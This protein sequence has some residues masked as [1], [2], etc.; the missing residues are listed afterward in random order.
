[1]TRIS[2]PAPPNLFRHIASFGTKSDQ[3]VARVAA[4]LAQPRVRDGLIVLLV[5]IFAAWNLLYPFDLWYIMNGDTLFPVQAQYYGIFDF[6]PP[7]SSNVFPD[8][9]LHL[10]LAPVLPDP[11]W[12]KQAVGWLLFLGMLTLVGMRKGV[13][14]AA[15]I[16]ALYTLSGFHFIDS[17]SHYALPALLL[18]YHLSRPRWLRLSMLAL[19]VFSDVLIVLPV[20]VLLLEDRDDVPLWQSLLAIALGALIGEVFYSELS[21]SLMEIAVVAPAF[22]VAALIAKRLGLLP[23]MCVGLAIALVV[24]VLSGLL[25]ARYVLPVVAS[26]VVIY[27]TDRP[28]RWNW[29]LLALPAAMA[30]IFTTTVNAGPYFADLARY[31]CFLDALVARNITNI[32]ADH[33]T[34]PILDIESRQRGQALTIT[35][36]DFEDNATDLWMAPY[37]MAGRPTRFAI[38]NDDVCARIANHPDYCSQLA[39]APVVSVERVCDSLDLVTY[40]ATIPANHR[41]R[42]MGKLDS[43]IHHIRHYLGKFVPALRPVGQDPGHARQHLTS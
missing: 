43:L 13:P 19:V 36:V 32:A 23:L 12:Q 41:S 20:I 5:V 10:A 21:A 27:S 17:T 6:R 16:V 22:A 37:D 26:F 8:M 14:A 1:M 35:Q 31:N 34:A 39:A 40:D 33:W 29:R 9:L 25:A 38:R 15:L 18:L 7:P 2:Q 3:A 42:P 4:V 28:W 24:G 30:A 11:L